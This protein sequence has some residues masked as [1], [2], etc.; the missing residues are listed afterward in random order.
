MISEETRKKM[1]D[2]SKL[3]A[4]E[5]RNKG[6]FK[7]GHEVKS[8]WIE[9]GNEKRIGKHFSPNTEWKKYRTGKRISKTGKHINP[10]H[11]AWCKENQLHRVPFSRERDS[12]S[13]L[14][15][16]IDGNR[17]N[18]NPENLQLMTRDFHARL[19]QLRMEELN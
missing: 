14:I 2:S 13:C 11:I 3:M 12:S 8:E 6:L 9:K 19:H 4:L 5:G 17:E 16:H 7:K 18:N 10:S 15:H 1:S